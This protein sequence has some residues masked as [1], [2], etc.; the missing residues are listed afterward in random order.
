MREWWKTSSTGRDYEKASSTRAY[1]VIHQKMKKEEKCYQCFECGK[2]FCRR[3]THPAS[4]GPHGRETFISGRSG[5]KAFNQKAH[6]SQ[7]QRT[8]T[9][10]EAL[11]LR[12][13]H[14]GLQ[15]GDTPH[16]APDHPHR[17][18]VP[19]LQ[20]VCGKALAAPPPLRTTRE[21][22]AER[23]LQVQGPAAEPFTQSAQL[24]RHQKI[25]SEDK[26]YRCSKCPKSFIRLFPDGAPEDSHRRSPINV[27]TARRPS[28]ALCSSLSTQRTHTGEKP[29]TCQECGHSL[30]VVPF[31]SKERS[32]TGERPYEC[33]VCR[34]TFNNHSSL[35]THDRT[36][37]GV[38]PFRC[39]RKGLQFSAL[40]T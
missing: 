4:E 13:V 2:S 29:Y 27:R 35:V 37:S 32:H 19:L 30:P 12:A 10:A 7:H 8:H 33:Q 39:M 15:P 40:S 21:S 6:L 17:R 11:H 16:P 31:Q 34:K 14:T 36:H 20:R 38:K 1:L 23:N 5:S 22:T 28:A 3:S 9:G 26:P 24:L 25:H 18:E